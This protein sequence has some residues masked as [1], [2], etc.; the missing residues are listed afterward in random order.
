MVTIFFL[1]QKTLTKT[2]G[3][4]STLIP[5]I[6]TTLEYGDR[7]LYERDPSKQERVAVAMQYASPSKCW[8]LKFS[9]VRDY[10]DPTWDGTYFAALVI[11]FFTYD[12]EVGNLAN[13]WNEE[14]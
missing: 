11:R 13:R 14:T 3:L 1:T 6:E 8:G 10:A 2:Y 5:H 7:T 12:R 9:W 4:R